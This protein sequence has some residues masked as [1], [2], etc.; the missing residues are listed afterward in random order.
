MLR[1]RRFASAY[2]SIARTATDIDA[3]PQNL[4]TWE[5]PPN[6]CRACEPSGVQLPCI[7]IL[8]T[9]IAY[10]KSGAKRKSCH[11]FFK[12]GLASRGSKYIHVAKALRNG[13]T[14]CAAHQWRPFHRYAGGVSQ[15]PTLFSL[16][17]CILVLETGVF[18]LCAHH[19]IAEATLREETDATC[20]RRLPSP[21]HP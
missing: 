18:Q 6:A 16:A 8:C 9:L 19:D 17:S 11:M 3:L 12:A 7:V 15:E 10:L 21:H 5:Q 2:S 13:P 20:I 14:G 1:S 4:G